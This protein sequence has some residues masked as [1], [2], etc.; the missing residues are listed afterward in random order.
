MHIITTAEESCACLLISASRMHLGTCRPGS[1]GHQ[2]QG[3]L[4]LHRYIT[5]ASSEEE[6]D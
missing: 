5:K 4:W 2:A 1:A 3:M 6:A